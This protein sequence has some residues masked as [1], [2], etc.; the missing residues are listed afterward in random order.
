MPAA[1]NA[2][3]RLLPAQ[4]RIHSF[5]YILC[6]S[7]ENHFAASLRS[8]TIRPHPNPVSIGDLAAIPAPVTNTP[9]SPWCVFTQDSHFSFSSG[10]VHL[11]YA[12]ATRYP[13]AVPRPEPP[14]RASGREVSPRPA[15]P[16]RAPDV[17]DRSLWGAR[18]GS[19]PSFGRRQGGAG[20]DRQARRPGK[21]GSGPQ[22]HVR[23]A[24]AGARP[25]MRRNLPFWGILRPPPGTMDICRIRGHALPK[26]CKRSRSRPCTPATWRRS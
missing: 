19:R 16:R 17:A 1:R 5:A 13:E 2:A 15:F 22:K 24:P 11:S 26:W 14:L 3:G 8:C 7:P 6:L 18:F 12:S 20:R 4:S 23:A 9:A 25:R 21:A 10:V